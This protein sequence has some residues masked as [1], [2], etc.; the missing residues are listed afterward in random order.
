MPKTELPIAEGFYTSESLAISLQDCVNLYP[1]FPQAQ[2]L[3]QGTLFGTP[4]IDLLTTTGVVQQENRGSHVMNGILYVVNGG[5]LY[6]VNR[7]TV[8]DVD[9]F[10]TTVLGAITGTGR[11]SI[12][13]NG[14]QL[15][16]LVPGGLGSIWDEVGD[17]F[18]PDINAVDSDF[19][20]NGAPQFV[21]FIDGFFAVTTDT[22]KF[23][24]SALNDGLSWNAL[25][26][27]TAEADPDTIVAPLAFRSQ[28]FI[29]GSETVEVFQNIGGSGFP[30]QRVTGFIIPKGLFAPFSVI[31]TS[32]AF[33]FIGGGLNESPAVWQFTGRD[34]VK[35]S[36]TAIDNV[37]SKLT[38]EEIS[39]V[40]AHSYADKGAYFTGFSLPDTWFGYDSISGRWHER[41]TLNP[42]LT[43]DDLEVWRV[44][45]IST[46]YGRVIVA[47]LKDGRIG[48][49]TPETFTEYGDTILRRITTAPFS[50]LGDSFRASS[51]ELTVESGVGTATLDPQIRLSFSDDNKR[52][53][54]E[55]SRGLG[56]IGQY[57]RRLIWYKQGRFARFRTLRFTMSDPVK[58]VLINVIGDG[59]A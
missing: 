12:S 42:A 7:T 8:D 50:N 51:I 18:T 1:N 13:D 22:K 46:A 9:Q 31:E 44:S 43:K 40:F 23:I 4:G 30:F 2:A 47:D 17:T 58:Y 48:E 36:T 49:L 54:N 20:A 32:G 19:T 45:S 11:V 29:F 34:V 37:L 28:L 38:D 16:I 25:D 55:I 53:S 6:R 21:V 57:N 52:F 39:N 26:F 56:K 59:N 3:G 35:V 24:V 5:T 15:M 27:G 33:M 10:D 14:I 41:R